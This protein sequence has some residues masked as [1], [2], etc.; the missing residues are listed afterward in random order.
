MDEAMVFW[1]DTSEQK[2]LESSAVEDQSFYRIIS[3]QLFLHV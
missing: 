1:C 2:T 3:F